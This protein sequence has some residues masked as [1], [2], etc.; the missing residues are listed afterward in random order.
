MKE[1]ILEYKGYFSKVQYS[2]EDN[3]LY[4][5]IEG[6]V[7]LVTFESE[8]C[9]EIEKEFQLA[10]DDY[11]EFCKEVGKSP[12][13]S[14]KGSFNI[15]ISPDLHKRADN[16]AK[17]K[18][19][20]L[21]QLVSSAILEYLEGTETKTIIVTTFPLAE[22]WATVNNPVE[23]YTRKIKEINKNGVNATWQM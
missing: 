21:N 8:S 9:N 22:Q 1:N 12:D 3:V 23:H 10:V 4:G 15:R 20:T 14:Y 5:K 11:L 13:K 18:G 17:K 7:D 19:I 2:S 16:T 6:I